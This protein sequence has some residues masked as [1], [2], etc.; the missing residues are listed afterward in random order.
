MGKAHRRRARP[1]KAAASALGG[2]YSRIPPRETTRPECS[3]GGKRADYDLIWEIS[4]IVTKTP[5]LGVTSPVLQRSIPLVP[6]DLS[7]G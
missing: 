3:A 5:I 4:P 1:D 7:S 2:W 6:N